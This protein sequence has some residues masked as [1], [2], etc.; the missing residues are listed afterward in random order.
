MGDFGKM[1]ALVA[2]VLAL[3]VCT[4]HAAKAAVRPV[5]PDDIRI[6]STSPLYEEQRTVPCL[7]KRDPRRIREL[8]IETENGIR[9][10]VGSETIRFRC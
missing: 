4:L 1:T 6:A 10:Y 8:W 3:V 5:K 7:A 9:F 2:I